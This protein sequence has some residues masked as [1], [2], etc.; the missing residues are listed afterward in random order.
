MLKRE[1]TCRTCGKVYKACPDCERN[2]SWRSVACSPECYI[3]YVDAVTAVRSKAEPEDIKIAEPI[4]KEIID[5][6]SE[7]VI[8]EKFIKKSK[9]ITD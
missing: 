5:D 6:I 9:I 3:A 2:G 8:T 1:F 4:I 7:D